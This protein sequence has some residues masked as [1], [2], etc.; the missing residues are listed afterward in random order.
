MEALQLAMR[1]YGGDNFCVIA[2]EGFTVS[3]RQRL[4]FELFGNFILTSGNFER[5][6]LVR[7]SDRLA[8]GLGINHYW[9]V[10]EASRYA[11]PFE[12]VEE[13]KA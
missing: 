6:P 9:G 2:H 4:R 11:C 12:G 7:F 10:T 13:L 5:E 1:H 3:K 8:G